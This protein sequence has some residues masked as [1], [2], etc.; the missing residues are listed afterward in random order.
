MEETI[1]VKQ[2]HVS[3]PF[4]VVEVEEILLISNQQV[5]NQ[6]SDNGRV[7]FK[8][9][10][11]YLDKFEG[12]TYLNTKT[13]CRAEYKQHTSTLVKRL[14]RGIR[15]LV[16]NNVI[17]YTRKKDFYWVNKSVIWK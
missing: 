1:E 2:L 13:I 8:Y 9:I 6:L 7:V 17:A 14:T 3:N 5:V 12:Q 11:K 16:E 4:K 10:S 15:D